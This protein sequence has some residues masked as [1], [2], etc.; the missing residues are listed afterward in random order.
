MSRLIV[1]T[2][3]GSG[4]GKATAERFAVG[5]D[6]LLLVGRRQ[7]RLEETAAELRGRF[8]G[9]DV[10]FVAADLSDL[11]GAVRLQE[12]VTRLGLPVSGLV[13]CA[14]SAPH[15]DGD[16]LK[17]V[18]DEWQDAYRANVMTAVLAVEGLE[19]AMADGGSIVFYSS[20]A[21]YR[22]SGGSGSY[23]AVKNA[24]H[25]YA[26]T[27]AARLGPR[28][29]NVNVIAPG[30][31]AETEFFGDRLTDAREAMLIRQTALGRAGKPEDVAGVAFFLCSAGG[32]YV[33]SQVVQ[34]NGGSSHGV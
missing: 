32:A 29:I 15:S 34:V 25:S 2:G 18:T 23:G 28:G 1:V 31:V 9:A 17:A 19:P 7:R 6:R 33:T 11:V 5:G 24:L 10:D 20:I 13:C 16:G 3:A 14:G 26:H 8:D 12:H 21:A 4:I 30:Y 22:G 27:L